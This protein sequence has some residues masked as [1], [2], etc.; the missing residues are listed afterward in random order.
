LIENLLLMV[1]F[2]TALGCGLMAG[3]FFAFSAFV[4]R[5]LARLP[6]EQGIAAMQSI[7][8]LAVTPLFMTTLFGT[9]AACLVLGVIAVLDWQRPSAA[10]LLSG[11]MVY[12]IGVILLTIVFNVPRNNAL[13]A[14]DPKS[15]SG[16][17]V[18]TDY[19]TGWTAGNHV[20]AVAG[21]V[22]AALLTI[23][24]TMM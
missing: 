15:A 22:A 3:V 17:R 8:L 6:S 20:R 19:L 11:G 1:T 10:Y 9:A 4:M 24:L 5:A 7:N 2:C 18:W 16:A 21:L 13:A 23:A 14:V 12:V